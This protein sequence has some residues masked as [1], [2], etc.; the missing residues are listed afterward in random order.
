VFSR[1]RHDMFG[2]PHGL[3][4]RRSA[5]ELPLARTGLAYDRTF[6]AWTRTV[7]SAVRPRLTGPANLGTASF[8]MAITQHRSLLRGLRREGGTES[9]LMLCRPSPHLSWPLSSRND[10]VMLERYLSQRGPISATAAISLAAPAATQELGVPFRRRLRVA[11]QPSSPA[12]GELTPPSAA[13]FKRFPTRSG[14]CGEV[15][16]E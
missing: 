6:I 13:T 5:D 15:V 7:L 3:R 16:C 11:H 12:R 2:R 1:I 14:T 9:L 8:I 10:G 4:E